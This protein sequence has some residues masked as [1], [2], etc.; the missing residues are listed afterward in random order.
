MLVVEAVIWLALAQLALVF[1]PFR[2]LAARFG[3]VAAADAQPG[4]RFS[5]VQFDRAREIGWA[6]TRAARYV[7]FRAVCLPQAIAA[8]A[9]LSRRHIASVMHFGVAKKNS[10][11]PMAA[12]AW[13]DAG[14]VEVTGYP[15]TPD[16]VEVARFL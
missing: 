13:L 11:T 3:T 6:V 2:L 10:E 15:V 14:P 5:E 12:H 1:V 7:P 8:K 9:M 16:F 4:N